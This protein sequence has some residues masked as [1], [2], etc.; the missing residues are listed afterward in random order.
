MPLALALTMNSEYT[1]WIP[2]IVGIAVGSFF[3]FYVR[4]RRKRKD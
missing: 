3:F 4:P 1:W 2:W